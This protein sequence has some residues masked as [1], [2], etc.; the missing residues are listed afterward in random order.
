ME[1]FFP[2]E[3]IVFTGNP[4]RKGLTSVS[5]KTEEA[6][7]FFN[8]ITD[9]PVIL[10][11]GGSLGAGTINQSVLK[12]LDLIQKTGVVIIWQSGKYYYDKIHSQLIDNPTSNIRLMEFIP[13]MDLAYSL[14]DVVISRAGAGTISELCVVGVPSILV[15][16][17]NVAEDHQTH[18]ALSLV[19][20]NAA[21]LVKDC[22]AVQELIPAAL[23]LVNNKEEC[24]RLSRNI[25]KLATPNATEDIVEVI[26]TLLKK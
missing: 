12:Y 15:P 24:N 11:V 26:A 6:K 19:E 2:A 22:D 7:Q 17:P 18:N 23:E 10:I 13:C 5:Q 16:S 21:I 20:K 1:R 4:I 14:A 9:Q 3:K 25:K 8:I